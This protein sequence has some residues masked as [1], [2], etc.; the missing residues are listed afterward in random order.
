MVNIG[1]SKCK[2]RICG[3]KISVD[4]DIEDV[5]V[6]E[7][8]MGEEAYYFCAYEGT[9]PKCG[10]AISVEMR[11]CEYPPGVLESAPFIDNS[12]NTVEKI[13]IPEIRFNDL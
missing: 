9:C 12:K 11:F 5:S 10:N 1:D 6:V 4:W 7:K 13:T 2:C 3:C 8:N